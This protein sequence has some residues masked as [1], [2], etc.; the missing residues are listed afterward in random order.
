MITNKMK[1]KT[2]RA[3]TVIELLVAM[4]LFIIL[5]GIAAGSFVKAMRTQRAIVA[6][7]AANDNA[8]LTLEQMAREV[9]TGSD[10]IKLSDTELQFTDAYGVKVFYKFQNEAIERG[11]TDINSVTTYRKIT[12]DNV[13][14]NNFKIELFGQDADDGYPPRITI[15]ISATGTNSSI[16]NVSTNIQTTI[17]SRILDS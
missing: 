15:S 1:L 7:M 6:L 9:R 5:M 8:S 13:K 4:G 12:A 17:S 3:F 16:E 2:F 14:I 10:F 11:T